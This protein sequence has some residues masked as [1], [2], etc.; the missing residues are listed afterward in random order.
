MALDATTGLG[1]MTGARYIE[2]L[3]DGREVWLDGEKVPDVTVHPALSGIV[4]ELAR[5][6]D[7]Q[8]SGE[9]REQMTFV[10]PDTGN[11]CSLS[12]LLPR[13]MEDLKKK[14]RNSEIWNEQSW[15]Q[16]GR[17]PDILAPHIITLYNAR[18]SLSAVENPHCD[19]GENL[20]NYHRYCMEN[21]LFLTHALGDPQVDRSQQPQNEQREISE[22]EVALH[23]VEETNEGVIV[24]GA[25]QLA[26][27]APISNETYVSLSA[28]FVRRADPRFI[29]AFSIP[30][31]TPGLKALCREPVSQWAGSYGHPLGM[32]YDEQDSML[33]F[34]N[35][36]VPWDRIF[37]LYDAG[38]LL[39]RLG[40][41]INFLGW[42]NLCRIHQR[43]RLMTA[44]ATLI[45]EAIGVIE[46]REVAAKIGEMVTYAEVWRHAMDG[47]E[48]NA[49]M[50][51]GGLMSLGS[52]SGMNIFFAQ[53]SARMVQL[54]REISGS[55]LIMQP[56]ENDLAN[57]ELRGFLDKYM[58]GKGVEVDYKSRL[59]RLAHDL[60][61][62]SFGMRQEVYEYW[63][64]G[65]PN[66][67]RINLLNTYDQ[68]D[69]ID[70]IKDLVS[71]PLAHG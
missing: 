13:T 14:R 39:Q 67:N 9:Y 34:E 53:T 26:T 17:S 43:M 52:M 28:T 32:L 23:V 41:G 8:H 47:L 6:Y 21:D 48:H 66:R 5:I 19:F 61:V 68:T 35:V 42:P 27:A 46:Y 40:S 54:L 62:S 20:V 51:D 45:A 36:L 63:H 29:L 22:E 11:R 64:G 38:P 30:T 10:S 50:T 15:G 57:P 7:L 31:N 69:M 2:S 70:R 37:M 16:L 24:N 65:D 59:Y 33:F 1:A 55:G 44:V 60:A 4:H 71:R 3:K 18:E 58:R 25:K 12:W 56:S 49:F